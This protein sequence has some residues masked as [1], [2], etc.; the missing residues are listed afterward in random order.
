VAK[1]LAE[2]AGIHPSLPAR[3][4][5]QVLVEPPDDPYVVA[6]GGDGL[7]RGIWRR[8][9]RVA[10]SADSLVELPALAP[11]GTEAL[12]VLCEHRCALVWARAM[13]KV[14]V[15]RACQGRRP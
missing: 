9:V 6:V 4:V 14:A 12:L 11:A 5:A 15:T 1:P 10:E 3:A 13:L 8:G 7:L 2:L